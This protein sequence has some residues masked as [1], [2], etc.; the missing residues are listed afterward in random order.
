MASLIFT[1]L[2]AHGWPMLALISTLRR[3]TP[4]RLTL[5]TVVGF[6]TAPCQASDSVMFGQKMIALGHLCQE[7]QPYE[8]EAHKQE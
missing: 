5:I 1:R 8:P 4:T 7:I 6:A 2:V 3:T